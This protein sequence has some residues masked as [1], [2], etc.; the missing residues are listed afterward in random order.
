VLIICR[1]PVDDPWPNAAS[2]FF[3]IMSAHDYEQ[4]RYRTAFDPLHIDEVPEGTIG[5]APSG[6]TCKTPKPIIVQGCTCSSVTKPVGM[7]TLLP[8]TQY[9]WTD[10]GTRLR[11]FA[12]RFAIRQTFDGL[13]SQLGISAGATRWH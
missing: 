10:L 13:F 8:V 1:L 12:G 9:S 4:L 11:C 6:R 3:T 7:L 2:G 5:K